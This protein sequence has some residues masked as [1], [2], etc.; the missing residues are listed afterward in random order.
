MGKVTAK[1]AKGVKGTGG[2][3]NFKNSM[4]LEHA[5]FGQ[6]LLKNPLI[7]D[8]MVERAALRTTDTVLEVRKL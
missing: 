4:R 2:G 3:S 8:G 6:H 5:K 1:K 7:V